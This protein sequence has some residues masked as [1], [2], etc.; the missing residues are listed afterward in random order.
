MSIKT[1][2]EGPGKGNESLLIFLGISLIIHLWAGALLYLYPSVLQRI[3]PR[4]K[5][6]IVIDV[7]DLPPGP[8]MKP[9]AKKP[10][11]YYADRS[12]SVERET[13][14][15][16]AKEGKVLRKGTIAV[17]SSVKREAAKPAEKKSASKGPKADA[18]KADASKPM[19]SAKA[20]DF[21]SPLDEPIGSKDKKEPGPKE[22]L[23]ET[24]KEP[25]TIE[26][27]KAIEVPKPAEAP[28]ST[29][30]PRP[31]APR[32]TETG[33]QA[34]E[35]AKPQKPNLFLSEERLTELAKKYEAEAPK[36]E[37]GKTLQLNTSELKYQKYLLT[38]KKRI[39]F[40]WD[41]PDVAAMRGWQGKLRIDFTINKD[42]SISGIK[43]IKSS[44][45]P[46]LDDAAITA[47]RLASPLPPF[48]D[49]FDVEDINIKASFEYNIYGMPH[50]HN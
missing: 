45:Y 31:T 14:P 49:D 47:L 22:M 46:V 21:K 9:D 17:P 5:P 44:N 42:G 12:Q 25:K 41:Y 10:P 1:F 35:E 16:D 34:K 37:R 30:A 8:A 13:Y 6:P 32:P 40:Y 18:P 11:S 39:E 33:K 43:L 20:E 29:E 3:T 26:P 2:P 48:P 19:K 24:I 27:P 23:K 28:K 36:G 7:V 15:F 50:G 4:E 38:M